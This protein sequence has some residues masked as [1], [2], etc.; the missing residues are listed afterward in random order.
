M[1]SI[2]NCVSRGIT[3]VATEWGVPHLETLAA[4][5]DVMTCTV[6]REPVDRMISNFSYDVANG[7]TR[8]KT[9]LRYAGDRSHRYAQHNYCT[10]ALLRD[11]WQIDMTEERALAL[12]IAAVRTI[13]HVAVLEH[14]SPMAT[15]ASALGWPQ[16]DAHVNA[17]TLSGWARIRWVLVLCKQG[18]LDVARRVLRPPVI[19]PEERR[20]LRTLNALDLAVYDFAR[21]SACTSELDDD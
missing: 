19:A 14:G 12:G 3:F 21:R 5:P 11:H 10:R 9:V 6:I 17:S 7:E 1:P 2:D 16:H 20:A 15:S 13:D 4:H 18:R 8:A